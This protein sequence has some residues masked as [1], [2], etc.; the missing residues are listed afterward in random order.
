VAFGAYRMYHEVIRSVFD[1]Y[2]EALF[3][4]MA[5]LEKD[6]AGLVAEKKM[7]EAQKLLDAFGAE[8]T[9]QAYMLAKKA[10]TAMFKTAAESSAWSRD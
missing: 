1:P 6:Y 5:S 4:D 3:G 10:I 2:E 9:E 8:K 7:E